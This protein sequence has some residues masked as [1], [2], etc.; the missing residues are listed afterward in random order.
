MNKEV[1]QIG[2][3]EIEIAVNYRALAG[4][5]AR[6]KQPIATLFAEITQNQGIVPI[7]QLGVMFSELVKAAGGAP[8]TIDDF[9]DLIDTLQ[10]ELDKEYTI[11]FIEREDDSDDL[12]ETYSAVM[13]INKH[14]IELLSKQ[15]LPRAKK[16]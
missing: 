14:V 13:V 8:L 4:I 5:E 15:L 7:A 16:K 1:I 10:D 3:K 6:L 11:P 9:Y 2:S 12:I